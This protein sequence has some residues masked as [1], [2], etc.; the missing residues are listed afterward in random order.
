MMMLFTQIIQNAIEYGKQ[1][2]HI[3]INCTEEA[4]NYEIS[5]KDDGVGIAASDLDKVFNSFYQVDEHLSRSHEGL[6]L[7]LTL[8]KHIVN[9][10]DGAIKIKSKLHDGTEII[11]DLP[12]NHNE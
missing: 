5:V 7:G 11:I 12:K 1:N 9:T 4:E 8:A 2:G 3:E 10:N 6:G